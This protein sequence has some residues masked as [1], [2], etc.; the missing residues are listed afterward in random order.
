MC[1]TAGRPE[2]AFRGATS[3]SAAGGEV[4]VSKTPLELSSNRWS[5]AIFDLDGVLTRT[6]AVHSAA[7]KALFDEYLADR[8]PQDGED[9]SEFTQSDYRRFVDGLP[10]YDGVQRF[11]ESRGIDLPWGA[12][13]DPPDTET[14]C[15]L[16][17]RKNQLFH[18]RLRDAGVD[19]FEPAI[20]LVAAL[21][22]AGIATAVVSSSKNTRAVLEAA[23]LERL[24]DARVDGVE[25]ERLGLD[26]KPA[27]DVFLEAARRLGVEPAD[28]IVLEDADSG[29]EAGRRG[30]FG[31]V[32]GLDRDGRGEALRDAG[33]DVVLSDL[34]EVTVTAS[35]ANATESTALPS[36]LERID[37]ILEHRPLAV[38]LDYDGT[39][40]PIVERPEDAVLGEATRQ[41]IVELAARCP[42]AIL[43]GRD[44]DDVRRLVGVQEIHYAGSHGFDITGPAV[45]AERGTELLPDLDEAQHEL[46]VA[47]ATISEA[48]VERKRFSLAVHFRQSD[49]ADEPA[50]Q[51]A[52]QAVQHQ[53]D[54]RLEM[55][56]GKKIHELR[57]AIDWH[58]GRALSWLSEQLGLDETGATPLYI[59]D[60]TT[61]EDAFREIRARGIGIVV[62]STSRSTA[63]SYRL[64]DPD[65]V[66]QLLEQL[67]AALEGEPA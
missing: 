44:L 11:L 4:T 40:T 56:S 47:L 52:V 15:G 54:G 59:G 17:N 67:A 7:W 16:G 66:R 57:P 5:A 34:E 22:N 30:S 43:S 3:S 38:F 19:V 41:A 25:A 21:R 6:A 1:G 64:H 51:H 62:T 36:A 58:K 65:E 20:R 27:P 37:E 42:V 10:R 50:I 33:A 45:T 18:E 24:F 14:I 31:L 39:L 53:H 46:E 2:A 23:D 32:I 60:D 55:S 13:D 26:G 35:E 12:S 48:W 28:A 61:D 8:P 63:A 49:P 29:V 9:H